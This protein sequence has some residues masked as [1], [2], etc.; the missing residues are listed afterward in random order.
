MFGP[1]WARRVWAGT[2]AGVMA[3]F[4]CSFLPL[5]D[6]CPVGWLC[7]AGDNECSLWQFLKEMNDNDPEMVVDWKPGAVK[8][9]VAVHI[10][11][12]AGALLGGIR[13]RKPAD[14]DEDVSGGPQA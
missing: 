10:A 1:T 2:I 7:P 8:T 11:T 6:S 3:F 12:I 14:R 9:A 13:K 4:I 5:W